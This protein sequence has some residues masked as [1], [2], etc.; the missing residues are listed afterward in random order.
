MPGSFNWEKKY[1]DKVESVQAAMGR[2]RK[3]DTIFVSSGCAEPQHLTRA[4]KDA[5]HELA[6]NEVIHLLSVGGVHFADGCENRL[7][8]NTPFIG[9]RARAL[10]RSGKADYTPV[11]LCELPRLMEKGQIAIDVA[12][13]QVSPPDRRGLCSL[14]IAV[15]ANLAAAQNARFVIA[16]VNP[17]MPRTHGKTCIRVDDIGVLVPHEEELIEVTPREPDETAR[18]ICRH[19]LKLINDGDTLQLGIGRTVNGLFPLLRQRKDLGVHTEMFTDGIVELVEDGVITNAKKKIHPGKVIATFCVGTRRLYDRLD[20]NP[21]FAFYPADY[22]SDP[23]VIAKNENV[24]AIN[25]ALQVDL[26]GQVCADSLGHNFYSGIGSQVDFIRGAARAQNG[27]PVI[28]L[29]STACNGAVSRIVSSLTPGAGVV[30]TRAD[31]HYVVTEFGIANVRGKSIRQRALALIEIA[32]PNFRKRLLEE[33]KALNYIYADQEIPPCEC[34]PDFNRWVKRLMTADG[35]PYTLRL[36]QPSDE[37]QL[38][39][40]LY[41]LSDDDVRLRFSRTAM[42][43]HHS[44]TQPLAVLDYRDRVAMVAMT[45]VSSH[46]RMLGF[47]QYFL[48]R[49]ENH[50]EVAFV[51]HEKY[52]RRGIASHLLSLLTD[53]ALANG[54]EGFR[55]EVLLENKGMLRVFYKCGHQIHSKLDGNTYSIWYSF[56]DTGTEEGES[57]D[58]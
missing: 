4:L 2:I 23:W 25:G 45:G 51:V 34:Q 7:R 24:V 42:T 40:L 54:V 39:K 28:A 15:E 11:R 48:D 37:T 6:D 35:T 52:R 26:T 14:G 43:F 38:Q 44:E 13:I 27:R 58:V 57:Q 21:K 41:S 46:E 36:I 33:A 49:T 10:V 12:M 8:L 31:V 16:Q 47:G 3:G 20:R 9:S 29:P 5:A 32:H 18:A 55:A 22:V 50:A 19:L 17:R 56:Y 1:A 30:T 53:Y